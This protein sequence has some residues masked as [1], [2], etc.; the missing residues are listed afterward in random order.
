V[1]I[2]LR[3]KGLKRFCGKRSVSPRSDGVIFHRNTPQFHSAK[4]FATMC[5]HILFSSIGSQRENPPILGVAIENHEP[6]NRFTRK[7]LS[8]LLLSRQTH[9]M[10]GGTEVRNLRGRSSIKALLE[11]I[12]KHYQERFF[13]IPITALCRLYHIVKMAENVVSMQ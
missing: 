12:Q 1:G 4:G 2:F 13:V 9:R 5:G 7:R 11:L 10:C 6:W 8:Q 3:P